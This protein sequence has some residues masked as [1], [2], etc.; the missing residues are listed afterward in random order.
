[1]LFSPACG[2]GKTHT[3]HDS[4]QQ[5]TCPANKRLDEVIFDFNIDSL[6]KEV[7]EARLPRRLVSPLVYPACSA[8]TQISRYSSISL[9]TPSFASF[10]TKKKCS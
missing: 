4:T 10:A 2:A 7:H 5:N 3:L 8:S 6:R 1:M 9:P